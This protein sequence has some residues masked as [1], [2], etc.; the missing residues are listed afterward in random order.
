MLPGF[1]AH[2]LLSSGYHCEG[3]VT[4][5]VEWAHLV[6]TSML[7]ACF[8]VKIIPALRVLQVAEVLDYS[9]LQGSKGSYLAPLWIPN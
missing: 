5:P 3:I 8:V 2:R 7:G 4:E 1:T 6:L 9:V